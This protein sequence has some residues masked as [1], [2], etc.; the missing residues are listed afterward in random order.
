MAKQYDRV[1]IRVGDSVSTVRSMEAVLCEESG[2]PRGQGSNRLV[3]EVIPDDE[4][5]P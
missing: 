1:Q 4:K 3:D 2:C 5:T